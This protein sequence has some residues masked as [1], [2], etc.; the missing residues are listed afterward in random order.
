VS[1]ITVAELYTWINLKKTAARHRTGV[2]DFLK[3]VPILEL[4]REIAEKTGEI[5]ADLKDRGFPYPGMDMVIAA[6]AI[7]HDLTLV[8]HNTSGYANVRGLRIID[9]TT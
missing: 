1:I 4:T 8:T 5:R 2:A 6:T 9:W 3:A 7:V